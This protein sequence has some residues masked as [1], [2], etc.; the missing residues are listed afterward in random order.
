MK[1]FKAILATL[2][3]GVAITS[4]AATIEMEVNG[5][6]CAF[7]AQGIEKKLRAFP[8][9]LDVVVSLEERLVAV[10]TKEGQDI[11]DDELRRAL[12]DA[13]YTVINIRREDESIDAVRARLEGAA[14]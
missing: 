5:L 13:G 6:V 3:V 12:T 2:L 11:P 8:A 9:T 1:I 14:H 4:N 7:C 10:S